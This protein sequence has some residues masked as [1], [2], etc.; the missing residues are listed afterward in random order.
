MINK[1]LKILIFILLF[2]VVVGITAQFIERRESCS[3]VVFLNGELSRD[4]HYVVYTH[5][6]NV[7]QIHYCDGTQEEVPTSRIIKVVEK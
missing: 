5:N 3:R 6:G 2:L 4:I 7:A 1:I